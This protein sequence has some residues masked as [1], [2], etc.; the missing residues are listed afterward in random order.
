V[1]EPDPKLLATLGEGVR[2]SNRYVIRRVLGKGGM[3]HVFEVENEAIGRR[4][5]L[6]II[7]ISF[8]SDEAI[9]R[10]RRE[11]KAL[12]RVS[13]ARVA[14]VIDFDVDPTLGPFLVMELLDGETL[15]QRLARTGRLSVD[16]TVT[17]ATELCEALGEVHA[18]GIVH[19][20]L[21]PSN[22]GLSKSSPAA[23]KL[24]DF[25]LAASVDDAFTE[26]LTQ[27]QQFL[28]TLPYMAPELFH[29]Q[30][31]TQA[32]DLYALG[33]VMFE[34]LAGRT[35]FIGVNPAQYVA[36]HLATAV[37][38]IDAVVSGVRVPAW[39][40]AIIRKLLEKDPAQRFASAAAVA[41]ALRMKDSLQLDS[42]MASGSSEIS[43]A[44]AATTAAGRPAKS[45]AWMWWALAAAVVLAGAGAVAAIAMRAKSAPAVAASKTEAP[46]KIEAPSPKIEAPL[47]KIEAPSP[48][49]EPP[50]PVA[51]PPPTPAKKPTHKPAKKAPAKKSWNGE[52]LE[53]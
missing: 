37:P 6:K 50:P 5:A 25:G 47:P 41:S 22:V 49:I 31:P 17:L 13:S 35:P 36:Q 51:S 44:V 46:P 15:Q 38:R 39:L 7:S 19:R 23:V 18:A 11:A 26:R 4:F 16:E 28:G 34:M 12:G 33:I 24:L 27:S 32:L 3:G 14:Q 2:V 29:G 30:P 45:R 48:K 53:E 10:F 9:K 40:E 21:K 1:P 8:A 42:T 43:G 52:I 20:D